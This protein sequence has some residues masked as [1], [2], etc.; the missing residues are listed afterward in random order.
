[1]ECAISDLASSLHFLAC[2]FRL[3]GAKIIITN[4]V[5]QRELPTQVNEILFEG[6]LIVLLKKDDGIRPIAV[7]YT[8]L[9]V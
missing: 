4:I 3:A 1:M 9:D 6:R 2:V 8:L 7:R 5:L